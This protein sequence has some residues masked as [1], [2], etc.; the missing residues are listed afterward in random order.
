MRAR[1][2]FQSFGT[3]FEFPFK[4]E[5]AQKNVKQH[6]PKS[7]TDR[8]SSPMR[9]NKIKPSGGV[10]VRESRAFTVESRAVCEKNLRHA[11]LTF[12]PFLSLSLSPLSRI[13]VFYFGTSLQHRAPPF[14]RKTSRAREAAA[15]D[16]AIASGDVVVQ[17]IVYSETLLATEKCRLARISCSPG[18]SLCKTSVPWDDG[19]ARGDK[20]EVASISARAAR[21]VCVVSRWE[22]RRAKSAARFRRP[23]GESLAR[24]VS[25]P[26]RFQPHREAVPP[27]F[28]LRSSVEPRAI[29]S[30][31]C[32]CRST[33][34][35]SRCRAGR[36]LY[37]TPS[38]S[39]TSRAERARCY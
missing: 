37:E 23:K 4:L 9:D 18:R 28:C 14:A 32:W 5:K 39:A 13:R 12:L 16:V 36:S 26:G 20:R 38:P 29:I 33:R 6:L 10:A 1:N 19:Y 27:P 31:R 17:K 30:C 21:V 7:C 34:F 15:E 2:A 3:S 11:S 22:N 24:G 8:R 35:S 25:P